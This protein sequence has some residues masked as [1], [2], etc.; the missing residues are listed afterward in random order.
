M[1]DTLRIM[2]LNLICYAC[3][4]EFDLS[5][6]HD[7]IATWGFQTDLFLSSQGRKNKYPI[8]NFHI[9]LLKGTHEISSI[10]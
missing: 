1:E 10:A 6:R 3:F 7:N 4:S 9:F 5:K 2:S 8:E